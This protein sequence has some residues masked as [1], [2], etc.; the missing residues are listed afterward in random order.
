MFQ[1]YSQS[2]LSADIS[3][4]S[5]SS[6]LASIMGIEKAPPRT[7]P[8]QLQDTSQDIPPLNTP[9]VQPLTPNIITLQAPSQDPSDDEESATGGQ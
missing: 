1:A 7:S 9:P 2:R 3:G 4:L 5:D 8:S 6:I